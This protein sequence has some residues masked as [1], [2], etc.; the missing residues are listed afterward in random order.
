LV[1]GS[2]G[3]D[4]IAI[5]G[6]TKVVGLANNR[7]DAFEIHPE[8]AGL[9]ERPFEE[10]AGG[11]PAENAAALKALLDG[12]KS[13]YRDAVLLNAA[14]AIVVAGDGD[15]LKEGVARAVESIDSG[16]AKAKTEALAKATQA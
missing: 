11:T 13:A 14:A 4:E 2:D 12:E 1:H 9:S 5:S 7:I 8:D 6:P 16:A 10:I 15:D 3:T